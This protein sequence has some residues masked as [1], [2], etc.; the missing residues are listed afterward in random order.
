[1]NLGFRGFDS[2]TSLCN[3]IK[4]HYS[5]EGVVCPPQLRIGEFVVGAAN[6]IDHNPSSTTSIGPF[7]G[8]CTS[9]FQN[10]AVTLPNPR[11]QL[12][13]EMLQIEKKVKEICALPSS[14]TEVKPLLSPTDMTAPVSL[15][16][17]TQRNPML[18]P[19]VAREEKEWLDHVSDH[20]TQEINKRIVTVM[21]CI[22]CFKMSQID[23]ALHQLDVVTFAR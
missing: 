6:N 23:A 14:F 1:M 16:E 11:G 18:L 12:L 15:S 8:T 10:C 21:G 13:W 5:N 7:H 22:P 4:S 3:N 17:D 2:K 20:L 19:S 9:L